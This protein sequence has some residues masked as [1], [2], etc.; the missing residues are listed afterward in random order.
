MVKLPDEKAGLMM[1]F[2]TFEK[3]SFGLIMK[4]TSALH[5]GDQIRNPE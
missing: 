5:V 4:A 2:R 3:V 1:V